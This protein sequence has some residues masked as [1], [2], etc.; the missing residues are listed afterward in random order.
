[1][2]VQVGGL[3]LPWLSMHS[4]RSVLSPDPLP[5]QH[6]RYHKLTLTLLKASWRRSQRLV[7][8]RRTAIV[9]VAE[10]MMA[11]TDERITGE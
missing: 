2:A 6:C 4:D 7:A 3:A 10:A 1:M 5:C 11:A 8:E 9:K